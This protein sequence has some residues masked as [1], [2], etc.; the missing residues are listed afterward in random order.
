MAEIANTYN[1]RA[2]MWQDSFVREVT[3]NAASPTSP[4]AL[5]LQALRC[6]ANLSQININMFTL[7]EL[8]E[9]A[10]VAASAFGQPRDIQ[11]QGLRALCNCAELGENQPLVWANP[12]AKA[13]IIEA[14]QAHQPQEIKDYGLELLCCM[15]INGSDL[16]AFWEDE[17]CR[18]AVLEAAAAEHQENK[19]KGYWALQLHGARPLDPHVGR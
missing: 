7:W 16:V 12:T 15:T 18:I 10:I 13:T 4:D 19:E 9:E 14:A 1:N 17:R 11:V 6:L 2:A 5:R 8:G 3:L